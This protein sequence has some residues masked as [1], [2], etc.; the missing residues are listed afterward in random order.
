MSLRNYLV[1]SDGPYREILESF[2]HEEIVQLYN[3]LK[4]DGADAHFAY[5]EEHLPDILQ[6]ISRSPSQRE[7]KKW[8]KRTDLLHLRFSA[9]QISAATVRFLLDIL[10]SEGIVDFG[11]YREF[12][13]AYASALADSLFPNPL[14]GFPFEGYPN[15]FDK[16]S[17]DKIDEN[18]Y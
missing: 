3:Q 6:Y 18:D 2:H 17:P 7:I 9:L 1:K 4:A 10:P 8:Q 14:N 15:P 13:S 5:V 11:S 16:E 12:H